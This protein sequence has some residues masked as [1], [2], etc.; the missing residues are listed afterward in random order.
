MPHLHVVGFD[1]DGQLATVH[2]IDP[3]EQR[4]DQVSRAE[5]AE[6]IARRTI[7]SVE[8]DASDETADSTDGDW[9][10]RSTAMRRVDVLPGNPRWVNGRRPGGN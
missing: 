8:S 10:T 1:D 9:R 7:E 6:Y 2:S 4:Y 5:V 3:S